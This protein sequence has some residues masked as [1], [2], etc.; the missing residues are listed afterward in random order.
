MKL[1]DIASKNKWNKHDLQEFVTS[2]GFNVTTKM[3][4]VEVNDQDVDAIVTQYSQYLAQMQARAAQIQAA[5]QAESR[6]KQEALASML[7][8]SGFSFDGYTITKYSGYISGDDAVEVARETQGFFGG[9][10]N[11]ASDGLMAALVEIRRNAL[12]E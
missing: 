7:I 2:A 5:A 12:N 3:F 10:Y 1:N 9:R 6:R 11:K 4:G 8:T